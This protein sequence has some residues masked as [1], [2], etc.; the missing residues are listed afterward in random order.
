[1]TH[2]TNDNP[3]P[4]DRLLS[5]PPRLF[6]IHGL[7]PALQQELAD[8]FET[9]LAFADFCTYLTA[10]RV[11]HH[12]GRLVELAQ[13]LCSETTEDLQRGASRG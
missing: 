8:Q 11:G 9:V 12:A 13:A 7:D 5:T 10:G 1:M 2:A 3:D 4:V 6:S